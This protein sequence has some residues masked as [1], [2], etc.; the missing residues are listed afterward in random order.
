MSLA[1]PIRFSTFPRTRAPRDFVASVTSVFEKHHSEIG[2]IDLQKGLTSDAVL[3]ILRDDLMELGW[4]VERGK[5]ADQKVKR[6][7]FFGENA[8]PDLQ[9]EVDAWHADW[10]SGLEVEAGRAWMGNAIYRDLIQALVMVDMDF[11]FLAVPLNYKYRT[12]GRETIS[13]DYDNTI[14]VSEALFGHSRIE[15]PFDLCVIGY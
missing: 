7:V 5:R 12:G 15:M 4:D 10:R 3:S 1:S 9:Y 14:A 11:L 2:T 6:P 8:L 13:R